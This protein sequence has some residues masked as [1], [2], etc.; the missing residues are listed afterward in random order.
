M[1]VLWRHDRLPVREVLRLLGGELAYTTVM[2]TLDRL[3]KKRL[4]TR[5][6]DGNAFVYAPALTRDEYNR[7]AVEHAVSPL[8]VRSGESA[9]AGFLD[10]AVAV[11]EDNLRRL[12]QLIAQRKRSGK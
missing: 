12:E 1:E 9:L 3:F 7:L 11:D 10:A 2:T 4:L 6:K 8:L 5:H